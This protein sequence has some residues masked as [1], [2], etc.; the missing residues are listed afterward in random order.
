MKKTV[1]DIMQVAAL[2]RNHKQVKNDS[3]Y[4]Y[5]TNATSIS[6]MLLLMTIVIINLSKEH[7]MIVLLSSIIKKSFGICNESRHY[8]IFA[9]IELSDKTYLWWISVVRVIGCTFIALFG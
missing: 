3:A 6:H 9:L 4:M 8:V 7:H 5:M 2:S 1:H